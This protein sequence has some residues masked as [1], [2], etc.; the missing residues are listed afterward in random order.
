MSQKEFIVESVQILK[1]LTLE[2]YEEVK[3]FMIN[4]LSHHCDARHVCR[5]IF[6][7]TDEC[8]PKLLEMK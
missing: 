5:I 3:V 7:M 6:K 4:R 2:Q 1:S 8:R